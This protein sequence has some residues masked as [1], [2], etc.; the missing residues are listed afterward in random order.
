MLGLGSSNPT[1]CRVLQERER[2]ALLAARAGGGGRAGRGPGGGIRPDEDSDD[3]GNGVG[4]YGW[5]GAPHSTAAAPPGGSLG[6]LGPPAPAAPTLAAA[7]QRAVWG[8]P[9]V[10]AAAPP[11]KPAAASSASARP[12]A[13]SAAAARPAAD[14][15]TLGEAPMLPSSTAARAASDA[16]PLLGLEMGAGVASPLEQAGPKQGGKPED[17][18]FL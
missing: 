5:P 18:P 7:G 10:N 11:H 4:A 3:D 15:F 16:D 14:V 9:P 1:N 17:N 13:A 2:N 12:A 8:P 6:P